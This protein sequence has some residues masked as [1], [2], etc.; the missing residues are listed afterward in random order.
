[1]YSI[2]S[3]VKKVK[4]PPRTHSRDIA[5][6][7]SP[8]ARVPQQ[9]KNTHCVSMNVLPKRLLHRKLSSLPWDIQRMDD[10]PLP[11]TWMRGWTNAP[12]AHDTQWWRTTVWWCVVHERTALFERI[13]LLNVGNRNASVK[14]PFIWLSDLHTATTACWAQINVFLQINY[15]IIV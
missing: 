6:E 7:I 12:P 1:M 11:F 10:A 5:A 13:F 3:I 15:N 8:G 9:F 14:D 4:I 2:I